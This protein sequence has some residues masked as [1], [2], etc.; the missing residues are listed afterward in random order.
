MAISTTALANHSVITSSVDLQANIKLL[1]TGSATGNA[2]LSTLCK[3][4]AI[5]RW[6]KYKPVK[7]AST[8]PS[9][10]GT[11]WK[12]VDNNCG[13]SVS[14]YTTIKAM[15][16][17]WIAKTNYAWTDFWKYNPPTG[18]TYPY[19]EL[20]FL[21][22]CHKHTSGEDYDKPFSGFTVPATITRY[23]YD[24]K[25]VTDGMASTYKRG[26]GGTYLL[27]L[28]DIT[29][30]NVNLDNMYFAVA[31]IHNYTASNKSY[32]FQSCYMKF[33]QDA[34]SDT[35][36]NSY[37]KTVRMTPP[38]LSVSVNNNGSYLVLPFLSSIR[39][40]DTGTTSTSNPVMLASNNG[41]L[42]SSGVFVPL[43]FAGKVV[44]VAQQT[45][46][47]VL[48]L[49]IQRT[50]SGYLKMTIT[51][52]NKTSSSQQLY[53]GNLTYDVWVYPR[54]ADGVD[55]YNGREYTATWG[56]ATTTIAAKKSTTLTKTIN[57]TEPSPAYGGYIN[58]MIKTSVGTISTAAATLDY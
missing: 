57:Y 53:Q 35:H 30:S 25:F 33:N 54:G 16:N 23:S 39:L 56:T 4:T 10:S 45:A 24:G 14:S 2:V 36:D 48:S 6:A 9:R 38:F 49:A 37:G 29:V 15:L 47:I 13:I 27:S 26:S 55:Y 11:W 20:D 50:S 19:R 51:A 34:T 12:S 28:A 40:W 41:A 42:S 52:T 44:T 5:N 21:N 17:A 32:A 22:Y 43:P 3:S 7:Y 1:L 18:G 46:N 58:A 8:A 31:I